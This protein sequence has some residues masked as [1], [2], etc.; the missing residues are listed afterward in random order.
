MLLI[1][2]VSWAPAETGSTALSAINQ[3]RKLR[4]L[5]G[6]GSITEQ[7]LVWYSCRHDAM[8]TYLSDC[9]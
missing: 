5:D 9:K 2:A 8:L 7:N 4:I 3:K 1:T 6:G